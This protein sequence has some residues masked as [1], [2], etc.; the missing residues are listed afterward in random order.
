MKTWSKLEFYLRVK[1]CIQFQG[2]AGE[3]LRTNRSV[4]DGP[5]TET[6]EFAGFWIWQVESME[7]AIAWVKP[8]LTHM[9]GESEMKSVLFFTGD[10]FEFTRN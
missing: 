9:L 4:T 7:E 6:K 1:D 3:V 2:C 10:D 8:L 5:F